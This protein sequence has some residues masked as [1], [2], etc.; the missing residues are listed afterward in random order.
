MRKAD[1]GS[2]G[3]GPGRG[4]SNRLSR[5]LLLRPRICGYPCWGQH[6]GS[7][8]RG[9]DELFFAIGEEDQ[10]FS[11]KLPVSELVLGD[12]C[13]QGPSV[14]QGIVARVLPSTK[15]SPWSGQAPYAN[16]LGTPLP[17]FARA[18]SMRTALVSSLQLL[19]GRPRRTSEP[20]ADTETVGAMRTHGG[21][22]NGGWTV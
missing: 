20:S 5:P 22:E 4:S 1:S 9:S 2:P 11:T 10:S 16:L 14:L 12:T 13:E 3:L 21:R 18:F 19:V 8:E 17:P 15:R 7:C 6:I